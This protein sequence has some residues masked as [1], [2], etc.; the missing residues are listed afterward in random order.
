[1]TSSTSSIATSMTIPVATSSIEVPCLQPLLFL[2]LATNVSNYLL[3]A[4]TTKA[5]IFVEH[6][7]DSI[8]FDKDSSISAF[9]FASISW[10][11]LLLLHRHLVL[12]L[13]HQY[14][15]LEKTNEL[16]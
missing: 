11:T 12:F 2:Q 3:W 9:V 15:E 8:A 1:M 7:L 6:L 4:K 14:L 10:K 16:W 5:H 13:Q